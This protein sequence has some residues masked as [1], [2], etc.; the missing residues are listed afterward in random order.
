MSIRS[1]ALRIRS[2]RLRV[3]F[4]G[5]LVDVIEVAFGRE[6]GR[7]PLLHLAVHR[8]L[9][10]IAQVDHKLV[11]HAAFHREQKDVIAGAIRLLRREDF[12]QVTRLQQPGDR[13]EV[14]GVTEQ[15]VDMPAEDG[16]YVAR[17]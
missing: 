16:V 3:F 13:A 8:P 11:R 10:H 14:Y 4:D 15:T 6:L 17:L 7:D 9:D 2:K 12:A 5:A 1:Q